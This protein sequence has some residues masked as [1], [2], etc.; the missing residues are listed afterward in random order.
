MYL[1][2]Y[3]KKFTKIMQKKGPPPKQMLYPGVYCKVL[4]FFSPLFRL[5]NSY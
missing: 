2:I 5:L 1:E 3:K 4:D